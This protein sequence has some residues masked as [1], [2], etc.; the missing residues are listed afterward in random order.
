[1]EPE[2]KI[3]K[4]IVRGIAAAVVTSLILIGGIS[5]YTAHKEY[6]SGK[7]TAINEFVSG[8][9]APLR[10][11]VSAKF[12]KIAEDRKRAAE[13]K[14]I[15][16]VEKKANSVFIEGGTFM[17]GSPASEKSRERD[18]TQREVTI[19]SFYIGKHEVTQGEYQRL[20]GKNPS[21][22]KGDNLPVEQVSW[23]DAVAFCN[24]K[25]LDEGLTPAY[26]INGADV[27]WDKSALGYRLPTEAEWEYACR[28]GSTT[29]YSFGESITSSQ[30]KYDGSDG[31]V[32]VGSYTPN[33]WGLYNMH[34][35]VWE[36]CWDRYGVYP[37]DAQTDP[38]GLSSGT[39]RVNRG[40]GWAS[41]AQILRSANR[42]SD[43]PD[44][45]SAYLGFRVART[46]RPLV[47]VV[48]V[49]ATEISAMPTAT[50]I[51]DILNVR[52]ATDSSKNNVIIQAH[53]GDTLNVTG[54][55][56][57][58]RF[59]IEYNG[60]AGFVSTDLVKMNESAG[61]GGAS[62]PPVAITVYK[63][64]ESG[65]ISNDK[66]CH[67]L[68]TASEDIGILSL[69]GDFINKEENNV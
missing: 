10:E 53:K 52:S 58:G 5:F 29:A 42:D 26:T 27:T 67:Y 43:S 36:W 7:I 19:S 16:S 64:N 15:K 62:V 32:T 25:S 47:P 39:S 24:A 2:K 1:L 3:I 49:T 46:Y 12:A 60:N 37:G 44:H 11:Y 22:K 17:M 48:P 38:S 45:K 51:N 18:E 4:D 28:A 21:K 31:P 61:S 34:G 6:I 57:K 13:I 68:E 54:V 30:A 23:Y 59:P 35:N 8:K 33:A 20:M 56:E 69:N 50:V 14:V 9:T 41:K 55:A 65:F 40:G 63:V 66:I